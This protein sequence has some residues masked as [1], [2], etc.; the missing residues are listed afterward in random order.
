M[1]VWTGL[2]TQSSGGVALQFL[3]Y[4]SVA[5]QMWDESI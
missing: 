2:Q 3:D 1:N 5:L 4:P